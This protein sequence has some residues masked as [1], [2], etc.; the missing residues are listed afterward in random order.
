MT[1]QPSPLPEC[2]KCRVPLTLDTYAIDTVTCQNK[3]VFL[4]VCP[5]CG[6]MNATAMANIPQ[7]QWRHFV[8]HDQLQDLV[9][10]YDAAMKKYG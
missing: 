6:D 9:Q 4:F 5:Q 1:P 10:Q 7:E 2:R 8:P 3:H